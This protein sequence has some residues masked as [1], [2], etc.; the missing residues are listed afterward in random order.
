MDALR[1]HLVGEHMNKTDLGVPIP[2]DLKGEALRTWAYQHYMKRYLSCIAAVDENVGRLLEFLD[3]EGLAQDTIVIYTSDQGFLL[4]EHGFYD[5]RLMDEPCLTTPLIVRYPGNTPPGTV[6]D[7]MVLN[8][9]HAPTFLDYAGAKIPADMHGKSYKGIVEGGKTPAD[10]RKS[11]YYRYYMHMD[12]AHNIPASYGVRT[13]RYTL[14]YYYGKALGMKGARDIPHEPEWELFDRQKDPGQMRSVYADPAY[15][16]TVRELKAELERL[17]K[18]LK[19]D[20]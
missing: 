16:T 5:K 2:K 13:D 1:V 6:N 17:R 19:D 7:S 4:G 20:K 8:I 10:W 9:D 12:G 11:I 15:A 3:K 14:V 18:E